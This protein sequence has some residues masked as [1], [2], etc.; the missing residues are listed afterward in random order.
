MENVETIIKRH[1]AKVL[2]SETIPDSEKKCNCRD[3]L[4]LMRCRNCRSKC[5]VYK[6]EVTSENTDKK[7]YY[8]SCEPE[9]KVRYRNHNKSFNHER[10]KNETEL[11][12]YI[13]TLKH[14]NKQY[15]IAW[16]VHDRAPSYQCGSYKCMLCTSEKLAIVLDED[17]SRVLNNRSDLVKWC[18]HRKKHQLWIFFMNLFRKWII[19][20]IYPG[21]TS[22]VLN[23]LNSIVLS[24]DVTMSFHPTMKPENSIS[25]ENFNLPLFYF[26]ICALKIEI[27]S[28]NS[29]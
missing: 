24:I 29:E 25:T 23:F 15:Q 2:K 13:W 12:K 18:L 19:L 5:I 28:W 27:N 8:G 14:Q 11:S 1:N 9:F 26:V 7:V 17:P 6:A 20:W 22:F 10:Y 21:N 3:E 16:S 4:Q